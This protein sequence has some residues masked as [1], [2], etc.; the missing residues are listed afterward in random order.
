[1]G[2]LEAIINDLREHGYE[3]V[4]MDNQLLF[5]GSLSLSKLLEFSGSKI[6]IRLRS[7]KIIIYEHAKTEMLFITDRTGSILG[8]FEL[9]DPECFN[10]LYHNLKCQK[11]VID[12]QFNT[13]VWIDI[14]RLL[15]LP[16]DQW[17]S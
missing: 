11:F 12:H 4:E 15:A 7:Y 5:T 6:N 2:I 10:K 9:S 8:S 3:A 17:I 1:M 13:G 14:H 16:E